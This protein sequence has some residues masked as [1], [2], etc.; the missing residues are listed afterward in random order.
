MSALVH[1]INP[2][3][4]HILGTFQFEA[5]CQIFRG[6]WPVPLAC[7][8][9]QSRKPCMDDGEWELGMQSSHLLTTE[10]WARFYFAVDSCPAACNGACYD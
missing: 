9:A 4:A 10:S 7:E 1:V 6:F 3:I 2:F 5:W 8:G